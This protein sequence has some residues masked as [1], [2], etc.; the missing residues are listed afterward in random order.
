M[1]KGEARFKKDLHILVTE[2][3]YNH[4][5]EELN[6]G[7]GHHV[8]NMISASMGHHNK[9]LTELEKE[10]AEIEPRY[11]SLKKQIEV[12]REEQRQR[13]DDQKL[14]DIRIEEA[15]EKLLEALKRA[16]WDPERIQ[17]ATFKIYADFSGESIETLKTW[18]NEQAKRRDELEKI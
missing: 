16:L 4:V 7:I 18:V 15:H 14:R 6:G 12:L 9:K 13:E 17:R 3:Q 2:D 10:F 5:A 1:P 11:L 8:R